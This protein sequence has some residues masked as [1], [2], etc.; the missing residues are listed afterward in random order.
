[1]VNVYFNYQGPLLRQFSHLQ[2]SDGDN[3]Q[4][5]VQEAMYN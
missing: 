4:D 1:M 5:K 2:A 3:R